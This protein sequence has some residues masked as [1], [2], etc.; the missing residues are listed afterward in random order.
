MIGQ[1]L[2]R[3]PDDQQYERKKRKLS[4]NNTTSTW[5]G[6]GVTDQN[7]SAQGVHT[8]QTYQQKINSASSRLLQPPQLYPSPIGGGQGLRGG[9]NQHANLEGKM[10]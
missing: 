9:P 8:L 7:R 4:R 2:T 1:I 6:Y 10:A 3:D 5:F